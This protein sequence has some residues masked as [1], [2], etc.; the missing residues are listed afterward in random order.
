MLYET[1]AST[2]A[3]GRYEFR[4]ITGAENI[5]AYPD[6]AAG[7]EDRA[8]TAFGMITHEKP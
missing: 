5:A 3:E 2:P 4:G 1:A 8:D 7:I 6:H